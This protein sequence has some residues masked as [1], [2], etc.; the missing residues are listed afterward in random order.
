MKVERRQFYPV[1]VTH[2]LEALTSPASYAFRYRLSSAD[3]AAFDLWQQTPEGLRVRVCKQVPVQVEKLPALLRAFVAP[4]MPLYLEFFWPGWQPELRSDHVS[5]DLRL[6][7]GKLPLTV[8]GVIEVSGQGEVSEQHL[9][10]E[11]ISRLPLVGKK[12]LQK[13]WPKVD[14]LLEADHQALLD[15]LAR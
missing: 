9:R 3:A 10:L 14:A 6:W 2:L 5:A 11:L 12:M 4:V 13:A 7:L 15:Y 1:S 8:A